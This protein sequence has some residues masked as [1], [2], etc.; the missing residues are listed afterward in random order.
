MGQSRA[1]KMDYGPNE[2]TFPLKLPRPSNNSKKF[3]M[4]NNCST[5]ASLN[6]TSRKQDCMMQSPRST[7]LNP[8]PSHGR[9]KWKRRARALGSLASPKSLVCKRDTPSAQ[10]ASP[11]DR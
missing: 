8:S 1:E 9:K 5:D 3:G 4:E 2:A 7:N 10:T 6:I 11:E